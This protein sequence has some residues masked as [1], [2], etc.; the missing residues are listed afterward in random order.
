MGIVV[1]RKSILSGVVH[2]QEMDITV[3][4]LD[5]YYKGGLLIQDAFPNL[6]ADEREFILS[7]ITPD[8][9][10]ATFNDEE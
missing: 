9:W 3:E 8:E 5:N 7:G 2:E 6:S 4:Q 1:V 10:D